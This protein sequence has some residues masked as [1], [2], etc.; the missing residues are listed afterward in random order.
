MRTIIGPQHFVPQIEVEIAVASVPVKDIH[1]VVEYGPYGVLDTDLTPRPDERPALFQRLKDEVHS[2]AAS[3]LLAP[4]MRLYVIFLADIFFGHIPSES[5]D[6]GRK[7]PPT[8]CIP[9]CASARTSFG[10]DRL[11]PQHLLQ[12]VN[13]LAVPHTASS[14]HPLSTIRSK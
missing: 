2:Q 8:R 14:E 4:Q 1:R 11:N 7:A 5:A 6:S 13:N 12:P 10:G 9:G 3:A